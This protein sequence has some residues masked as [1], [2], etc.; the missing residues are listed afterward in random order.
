MVRATTD[1]L[2]EYVRVVLAE[3]VK[4][5]HGT[6]ADEFDEFKRQGSRHEDF[7]FH[8]GTFE[9]AKQRIE[10]IPKEMQ[11]SGRYVPGERNRKTGRGIP[12]P[13]EAHI[14]EVELDI[15]NPLRVGENRMGDWVPA[16]II[17]QMIEQGAEWI[18]DE[19]IEAHYEDGLICDGDYMCDE[20]EANEWFVNWL[21]SKGFDG[22]VYE[23]VYE[24]GGD[25]YIAFRPNQIKIVNRIPYSD[26]TEAA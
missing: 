15:K 20:E 10:N 25:S 26:T 4:A 24:G 9:T 2:R 6:Y 21:E 17:N 5:Y 14:I 18:T 16:F 19:E 8:F 3:G 12:T 11:R 22:I 23:N 1:L 13:E 7:G